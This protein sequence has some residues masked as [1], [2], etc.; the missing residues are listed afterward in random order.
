MFFTFILLRALVDNSI[1]VICNS[2]VASVHADHVDLID[3][4][5]ETSTLPVD[6]VVFTAGTAPNPL[7]LSL[8][9]EKNKDGRICTLPTLQCPSVP[10]IFA[11][12]DCCA[13]Q[14]TYNPATAQV[15]MQQ[16]STVTHNVIAY[17][18]H[19]RSAEANKRANPIS[20]D[21][22]VHHQP[23]T[24]RKFSFFSLGEMLTLGNMDAAIT[25]FGGWITL[26]GPYK[27][28]G[29]ETGAN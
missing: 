6:I 12:G 28:E 7:V 4:V 20:L 10:S 5:G 19:L 21:V 13:V 11:L 2:T 26:S 22:H 23:M 25:S 27:M 3:H 1:R 24:F 16:A 18:N 8:P 14:G 17:I 9:V 29:P 15:A